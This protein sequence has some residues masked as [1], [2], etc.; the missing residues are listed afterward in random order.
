MLSTLST[1]V[2]LWA[3]LVVGFLIIEG[4]TVAL[5]SIWF[6]A[7]AAV[8]LL[9]SLV[10]APFWVQVLAFLVVS[11]GL[12]AM[13]RPT[14]RKHQKIT[15]TNVDSVIGSVGLVTADIDNISAA[16][17]VKLGAMTWT[18]RS[19]SGTPIPT[20][21]KVRVDRVEGVKVFVSPVKVPES[22]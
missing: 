3:V 16:G 4:S 11:A 22:V 18:A 6:S 9:L 10:H 1:Q 7:G 13:L 14:L 5:V 20:G 2:I 15:K 17:Q 8:A 12:L 19:T 21:T